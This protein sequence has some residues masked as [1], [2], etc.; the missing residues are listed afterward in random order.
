MCPAVLL[1]TL[2][3]VCIIL[4]WIPHSPAEGSPSHWFHWR[5][6]VPM[7]SLTSHCWLLPGD[8]PFGTAPAGD[9]VKLIKVTVAQQEW[10]VVSHSKPLH[11]YT[12]T[13][14]A[15]WG[16]ELGWQGQVSSRGKAG[17]VISD[18]FKYLWNHSWNFSTNNVR[19][20]VEIQ[21]NSVKLLETLPQ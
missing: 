6:A 7:D 13:G 8:Q 17:G 2:A 19:R 10:K 12:N 14:E 11:G 20:T 3:C 16:F 15:L 4:R 1:Q 9:W 21:L 18:S 5:K